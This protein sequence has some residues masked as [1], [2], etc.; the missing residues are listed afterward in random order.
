MYDVV[1]ELDAANELDVIY[2]SQKFGP[3]TH[4]F[5]PLRDDEGMVVI[6]QREWRQCMC[7]SEEYNAYGA[8]E[9]AMHMEH[10]SPYGSRKR[11]RVSSLTGSPVGFWSSDGFVLVD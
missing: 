1:P 3:I 7:T 2:D 4:K 9:K 8:L 10:W 6:K 11:K 5:F